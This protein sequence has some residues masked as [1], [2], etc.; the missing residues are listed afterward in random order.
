MPCHSSAVTTGVE[1]SILLF[2]YIFLIISFLKSSL[3]NAQYYDRQNILN[4]SLCITSSRNFIKEL[5]L[6]FF[7]SFL[8]ATA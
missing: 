4:A 7:L 2:H 6:P 5:L 1:S 8:K 3:N